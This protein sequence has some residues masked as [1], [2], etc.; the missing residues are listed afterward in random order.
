MKNLKHFISA[1][2]LCIASVS[3]AQEKSK[4]ENSVLWKIEHPNLDQPSYLFGTLHIMCEED[5]S[6]PEKVLESM[7]SVDELVLEVNLSDPKEMQTLQTE[8]TNASKISE[9]LTEEQFTKLDAFTQKIMGL[10]LHNFDNYG[11][12]TLYSMMASKMLPCTRIKAMETELTQI[13]AQKNINIASL[14]KV[15]EQFNY[16]KKAYPSM[17]SYR[18]IFLFNEYKKDF[19]DAIQFYKNEDIAATVRLISQEKYMNSNSKHYMLNLRNTKWA[20]KMPAMM[21]AKSN[22]FAIGAAHLVGENGL[23]PL[24]REKGYIVTPVL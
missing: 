20:T 10:P 4:L 17:E 9:D 3:L 13:A 6:I 19:N 23:I 16:I 2:I 8:M 18:L 21:K 14:E 11:I 22:L 5:F 15:S 7:E 1:C 12:S 24:L